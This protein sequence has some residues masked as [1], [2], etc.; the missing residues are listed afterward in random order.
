MVPVWTLKDLLPGQRCY[1]TPPH[2]TICCVA[3]T[4]RARSTMLLH[5]TPPHHLLRSIDH[6]CQVKVAS[7]RNVISPTPPHHLLRSIDHVCKCKERHQP[8]PTPPH[9]MTCVAPTMCASA[10]NIIIPTPPNPPHPMRGVL[11]ERAR[12]HARFSTRWQILAVIY[13][14][15]LYNKSFIM[16]NSILW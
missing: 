16:F 5:P 14:H 8:N 12:R 13:F 10:R 9:P 1:Y 3:L 11:R 15:I 6:A 4:M 2:P 7:A